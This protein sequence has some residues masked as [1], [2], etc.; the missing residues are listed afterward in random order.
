M[1]GKLIR[2]RRTTICHKPGCGRQHDFGRTQRLNEDGETVTLTAFEEED[3]HLLVT[4]ALY[5][6]PF[7]D[8]TIFGD[9]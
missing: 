3:T 8:A 4:D 2:I 1:P 7:K 6:V 9:R 5:E